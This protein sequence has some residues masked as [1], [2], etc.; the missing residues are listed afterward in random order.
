MA[1]KSPE[2]SG[3]DQCRR[4]GRTG[5]DEMAKK[6]Y[7]IWKYTDGGLSPANPDGDPR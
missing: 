7:H 4:T 6:P 2:S 5:R 3:G 1:R